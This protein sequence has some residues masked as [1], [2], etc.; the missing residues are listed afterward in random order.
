[1]P[2]YD[3]VNF[4]PPAP[5]VL[6]TV[7]AEDGQR[8]QVPLL[9]DSGADGT[10]IPRSVALQVGARLRPSGA[11]V[12]G[13]TGERKPCELAELTVRFQGIAVA[14]TFLVADTEMGVLGRNM[15]NHV[16]LILD[17]PNLTW[18]IRRP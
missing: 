3:S 5:V 18:E 8:T 13:Y 1:M 2:D 12:Q 11:G 14:G 6:A 10:I 7:Q 15:L 16:V 4:A 17:G 9:L